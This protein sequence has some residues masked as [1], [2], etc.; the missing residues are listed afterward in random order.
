M[1]LSELRLRFDYH[2]PD[3]EKKILHEHIRTKCLE[4]A[5]FLQDNLLECREN[6]LAITHLED[7]MMW[8]NAAVARHPLK[9]KAYVMEEEH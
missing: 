6:S 9:S 4:L 2:A 5:V 1:N 8:A 7:V 3:E